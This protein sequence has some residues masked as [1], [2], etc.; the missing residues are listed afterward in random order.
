MRTLGELVAA[1][2]AEARREPFPID[3]P[4][5]AAAGKDPLGPVL[6]AGAR[7]A[8]ICSVGRD[9]GRDEVAAGEPQVGA[10]GRQVRAG[11]VR[12][13]TGSDPAKSDR[14]LEAALDHVLLTNLVPYKPPGNKAYARAVRERFRPFLL[15]LLV[16]HWRGERVVTL[17]TEAFDWFAPYL[18]EGEAEAFWARE[19]RYEAELDVTLRCTPPGESRAHSR[20]VLLGPLP[21]PSPLNQ[22]WYAR[23]PALL[24]ARLRAAGLGRDS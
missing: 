2:E 5:Y 19:D 21:H 22:R 16:V 8:P 15:E 13:V 4:V 3:E 11:V 12:A 7:D 9:L 24:A 14:R 10:A 23:F 6:Y 18:P 1:V 17:G 20:R